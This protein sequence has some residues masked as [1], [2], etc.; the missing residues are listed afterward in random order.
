MKTKSNQLSEQ[1][2]LAVKMQKVPTALVNDLEQLS[3]TQLEEDLNIDNRKTA[4]WINIYNAFFQIL[5]TV[6]QIDKP[7]IYREKLLT[8]AHQ[9]LSLDDIEHGILRKYR[10]KSSSDY[11]PN[12]LASSLI[13]QLAVQK[14]DYRIHFALNCGAKSCPPIAFYT[15]KDLDQ[16]LKTATVS[17]LEGETIVMENKKE[18]HITQLFKWFAGDFGGEN[19][20]REI[21]KKYLGLDTK[22]YGLVYKDY[23]WT[24]YL[25]NF[26]HY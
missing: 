9:S 11:L 19:G 16:Q 14:I 24:E 15:A 5:R 12:L 10:N 8:I 21:L 23:D 17:F 13:K 6:Y 25:D 7:Q 3:L 20:V 2:L 4:F 26:A 1:L 22:G 18:V